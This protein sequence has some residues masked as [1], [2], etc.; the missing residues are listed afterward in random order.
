MNIGNIDLDKDIL[1]IAEI[2]NNHEGDFALAEKMIHAAAKAGAG[3]VKFQTIVPDKLVAPQQKDAMDL[4]TKF[5]FSYEQFAQLKQVADSE[6]V[7]FLSTPFDIESAQFLDA[8]VP[9]FKIASGD[10]NYYP[11]IEAV[12]KT[13]KPI[14]ISTGMAD[15]TT[16][17]QSKQLM[18]K[19]WRKENI[20]SQLVVLHCVSLYPTPLQE[21][22]LLTIP[23][24][25]E[26]LK[27]TVGYSDHTVGVEAPVLAVGLG[28]RVIE[29]HFT[30][31]KNYSDFPD[32]RISMDPD[33]LAKLV[34]K[35]SQTVEMLGDYGI[36]VGKEEMEI[37]KIARRSVVAK[38]DLPAGNRM[39]W[40]DLDWVRPGGGI[41]PGEEDKILGKTLKSAIPK[42]NPISLDDLE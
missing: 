19:I 36:S 7:M 42:G 10:N 40:K 8:L 5:Q 3:A 25:K 33:D 32:H 41:P 39:Q 31:D 20:E 14:L 38:V 17:E 6:G 26:K 34:E 23:F 9:A 11:L 2:G 24:L 16:I 13:G 37:A 21:A 15:L 4:F 28:A 22:N 12:A 18:E 30:L 27:T 29:K 35:V 1:I